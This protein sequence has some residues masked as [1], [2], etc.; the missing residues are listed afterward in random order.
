[1]KTQYVY[2]LFLKINT[3]YAEYSLDPNIQEPARQNN[4]TGSD[5]NNDD[6]IN[7]RNVKYKYITNFDNTNS[8][9]LNEQKNCVA[10]FYDGDGNEIQKEDVVFKPFN[11]TAAPI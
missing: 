7:I 6:A 5:M 11:I 4:G 3:N 8:I 10:I 9:L 2:T 1:M